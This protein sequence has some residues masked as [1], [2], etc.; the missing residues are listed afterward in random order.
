MVKNRALC[1][2]LDEGTSGLS[3]SWGAGDRADFYTTSIPEMCGALTKTLNPR[4]IAMD[5]LFIL[6]H[7]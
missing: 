4:A 1:P 7:Q 3:F 2:K 6:D 5:A